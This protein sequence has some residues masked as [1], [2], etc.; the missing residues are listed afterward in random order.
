VILALEFLDVLLT[1][2]FERQRQKDAEFKDSLD[3]GRLV[4]E[5]ES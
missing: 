4:S 1:P 2:T 5:N 3:I